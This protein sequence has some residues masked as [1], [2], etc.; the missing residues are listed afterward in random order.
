MN[1][2]KDKPLVSVLICSYNAERFIETTITSVLCQAYLNIELLILDNNS[3]DKTVE[4]I[5]KI[6]DKDKRVKLFIKKTNSGPYP[7]LNF[8]LECAKGKYI[9][10]NDHDDI[11]HKDKLSKQIEFLERYKEYVGCGSAIINWYEKYNRYFYRSQQSDASIAWHTSLVFRNKG[12]HYDL[13]VKIATDFYFMRNI[14]CSRKKLIY[15]FQEP[16]VLRRIFRGNQNLSGRWMKN[17]SVMDILGL[18]IGLFD[19][20]A[21]LNRYVLP[22]ELVERVVLWKYKNTIPSKYKESAERLL[23]N[24]I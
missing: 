9:A 8:L 21:L 6:T 15:N 1:M 10:I 13:S 19:K 7:G 24:I 23:E 12:F 5:K 2:R 20:L 16:L 17:R 4:T 14:L 18:K 22:Q 11:W 3:C